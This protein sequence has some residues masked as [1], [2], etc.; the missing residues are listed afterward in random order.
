MYSLATRA[1]HVLPPET[2]HTVTIQLLKAGLGP[3][4]SLKTPE[5]AVDV[6]FDG[7]V[8]RFPNCVG[9]AAGFDKNA[10][11]PLA[12]AR[13]G[14]GFV[15]CGTVTPLS[16]EGN[17]KPRLF[18]LREDEAVINRMGFNNGGLEAYA[19]NL[20]G[21]KGRAVI[22]LNIGANKDAADRM[23][24]YVTGLKRLWGLGSYFTINISSP[25]TPGLRALQGRSHL[26]DLLGRIAETRRSLTQATRQNMPVFLKIA[27]D[28]D[29]AEIEDTVLATLD[30]GLEGL[31]VSNTTLSRNGLRSSFASEAGGMSGKP[32]FELSTRALKVAATAAAG[33]LVLIGAGGISSGAQAYAKIRAGASLVQL[34]SALVYQGPGLADAVRRDLVARLKADGFATISEAIGKG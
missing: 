27:P 23:A 3:V 5:L 1:L 34:Y 9:L 7:G 11:V 28:L 25:N 12:M 31:I 22:G 24:D 19:R 30:H 2:A 16:Q 21:A 18:R 14:F 13:A 15:E 26:D 6:P 8:L 4:S 17:P 29:D 20:E 10:D 32:L 33:R